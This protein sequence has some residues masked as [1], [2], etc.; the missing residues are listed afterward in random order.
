MPDASFEIDLLVPG[1]PAV[2]WARLWDLDRHS[3]AVPLTTAHGGSLALD[4]SFLVSTR[5]GPVHVDDEMLVT[6]WEPPRRAVI[7]KVGPVLGGTIEVDLRPAGRDTRLLWRQSYR[8]AHVPDPLVGYAAPLVRAAY[9][10]SLR[11]IVRP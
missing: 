8:A 5:L 4:A 3:A 9:L 6:G 1:S 7:E 11:R 10:R 2:V